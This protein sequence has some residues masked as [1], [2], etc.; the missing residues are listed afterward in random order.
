MGEM[1]A[2]TLAD[3]RNESADFPMR[4]IV[5]VG[6]YGAE[7]VAEAAKIVLCEN[8]IRATVAP[9]GTG[10]RGNLL[11]WLARESDVLVW[12]EDATSAREILDEVGDVFDALRL[13]DS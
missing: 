12:E 4:D 7:M 8:G 11:S 3:F 2:V 13:E 5:P 1:P 9:S 6:T 10:T